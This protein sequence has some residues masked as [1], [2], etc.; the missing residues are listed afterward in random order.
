MSSTVSSTNPEPSGPP[1]RALAMVLIS[2]AILFAAIGALSLTGSDDTEETA[3]EPSTSAVE[4]APAASNPSA[5]NPS[6]SNP[7]ASATS[8]SSAPTSSVAPEDVEVRVLNN[9]NVSGLAAETAATLTGEGWTIAET[10]NYS[11]SQVPS[12]TVYYGT[13]SGAQAAAEKIAGQ[14][15]ATA[16][17]R[18]TTLASY[19][20]GVIV[21]VTQ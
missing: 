11:E 18:P 20:T 17:A 13:A 21:M 14:I 16:E 9:S 2:L 10:G 7:S 6:A 12:T 1:L 4:Q 15:G 19:G 5:S 8:Q 3:S